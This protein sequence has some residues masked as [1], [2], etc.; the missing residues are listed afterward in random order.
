MGK[1]PFM[2]VPSSVGLQNNVSPWLLPENAYFIL[3][4][5]YVR[6]QRLI[7]KE[8]KQKLGILVHEETESYVGEVSSVD[9]T[10]DNMATPLA[11]LP[12]V[13]FSVTVTIDTL[14][15]TDDGSGVMLLLGSPSGTINYITGVISLTFPAIGGV[16][17]YDVDVVYSYHPYL[18]I[19]GLLT[20]YT[21]D[22]DKS[23]TIFFDIERSNR[24]NY[25]TN[26]FNDNSYYYGTSVPVRWTGDE[27]N[28][29]WYSNYQGSM[30]ATSF[31]PGYY[32]TPLAGSGAGDGIRFYYETGTT[33]GWVNFMPNVTATD[34]V[35]GCR[36]IFPYKD[37]LILLSTL[38]GPTA[39]NVVNFFPQRA[40][41]CQ[42]GTCY[43][44]A[45]VPV[46][47]TSTANAWRDDIPGFGGFVDAPTQEKIVGAGY[48]RDSI[49]VKFERSSWL[50]RYTSNEAL[51]FVWQRIDAEKGSDATFSEQPFD[52]GLMGISSRGVIISNPVS[53]ERIDPLIPDEVFNISARATNFNRTFGIRDFYKEMVYWAY[54]G[55]DQDLSYP[56]RMLVYNYRENT[57]AIFKDSYN[58]LGYF[59]NTNDATGGDDFFW[60][61]YDVEWDQADIFWDGSGGTGASAQAFFQDIVGGT[62]MG[63]VMLLNK[64]SFNDP[65]MPIS[66]ITQ[67]VQAV[68]TTPGEHNLENEMIV[69]I[70]GVLGMT[71]IN[72][73]NTEVEVLSP[74]TFRCID[75][76]SSAFSAYTSSG[77]I[78]R[79]NSMRAVTKRFNPFVNL[80]AGVDTAYT[81][82]YV[83]YVP[84]GEI[85]VNIYT[86]GNTTFP[87]N[88]TLWQVALPLYPLVS[89]F[90][91][92]NF[93]TRFNARAAGQFLQYELFLTKPQMMDDTKNDS[94]FILNGITL[95]LEPR[96][97]IV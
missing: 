74:T 91:V 35:K 49:V 60:D 54:I 12:I 10:W 52:I 69:K 77:E 23:Q 37:R 6:R 85:S 67:A 93:W 1:K 66:N 95:W 2:I 81:D 45:P 96:T 41:W 68:V 15:F 38:E 8:C 29:F 3:E 65:E 90:P 94:G 80:G 18:P 64:T 19:V 25:L 14:V 97:R 40:R 42:N 70:T 32:A 71:Q 87:V 72:D 63:Y 57:W 28:L 75:I 33:F 16:G 61:T 53:A 21:G 26:Q 20:R 78:T 73:L 27:S 48:I 34:A 5:A 89:T 39:S 17:P 24:F 76:D 7:Q 59:Q 22:I 51:P 44:Q 13:P 88:S 43:Y 9:T 31:I 36:L 62:S 92:E 84:Q 4:D 58:C 86:S 82:F 47:Q 30:F 50:L 79:I 55:A 11:N 56:N 46:N 83:D